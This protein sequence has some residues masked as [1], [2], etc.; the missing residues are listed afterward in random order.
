MKWK[1]KWGCALYFAG[2]EKFLA[3]EHMGA[4]PKPLWYYLVS[5]K[6]KY[7]VFEVLK[8]TV[9]RVVGHNWKYTRFGRICRVCTECQMENLSMPGTYR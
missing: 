3:E 7:Y 5:G 1:A 2:M 8:N 6:M 4:R 9:C